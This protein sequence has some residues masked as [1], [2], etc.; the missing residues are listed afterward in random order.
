M[1]AYNKLMLPF[2]YHWQNIESCITLSKISPPE[3]IEL[4][5]CTL[6]KE[7]VEKPYSGYSQENIKKS[8]N[9]LTGFE[10]STNEIY[11]N[12]ELYYD[13]FHEMP[14][15]F[16]E[17]VSY[18]YSLVYVLIDNLKKRH[19]DKVFQITLSLDIE[20]GDDDNVGDSATIHFCTLRENEIPWIDINTMEKFAQPVFV[21]EI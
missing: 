2:I 11:T 20:H 15:S 7:F 16:D 10:S 18:A 6:L 9:D 3:L 4:C 14:S 21:L 12:A 5:G 8:F 17:V 13:I 1:F 19:A